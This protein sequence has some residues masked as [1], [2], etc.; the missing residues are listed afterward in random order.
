MMLRKKVGVQTCQSNIV[1]NS[2]NGIHIM[3]L[4]KPATILAGATTFISP[5]VALQC[6]ET[7]ALIKVSY[8]IDRDGWDGLHTDRDEYDPDPRLDLRPSGNIGKSTDVLKVTYGS[9]EDVVDFEAC[10]PR[11]GACLELTVSVFPTDSYAI[12]WDGQ[13]VEVGQEFDWIGD[14]ITSTEVGNFC[15]PVCDGDTE[16]LFE[17]DYWTGGV[18][19][20]AYR[21]EDQDDNAIMECKSDY[22]Y[23]PDCA[24]SLFSIYRRRACLPKEGCY[25]FIIGS[26]F[27]WVPH[28]TDYYPK[29]SIH[30]DGELVK[31]SN[32]FWRFESA[33]FGS[34][35]CLPDCNPD[36]ESMVEF[37]MYRYTLLEF[38]YV[39]TSS[40]RTDLDYN[41]DLSVS[42]GSSPA[43]LA[44]SGVVPLCSNTTLYHEK[45]CIPKESCASFYLSSLNDTNTGSSAYALAMDGVSYRNSRDYE[46]NQ[47]T[48]MGSCTAEALCDPSQEVLFEMYLQTP[49]RYTLDGM[50]SLAIFYNSINWIFGW[51][52]G[53]DYDLLMQANEYNDA[54][55]DFNSTYRTIE[56][57][58]N[59]QCEYDFNMTSSSPVES[60]VV[61]RSGVELSREVVAPYYGGPVDMTAFGE[62]NCAPAASAASAK[63]K[64]K[65][66]GGAIA[67]IVIA[68]L[69]AVGAAIYGV[70][71]YK[72][73]N[74]ATV[75]GDTFDRDT[76]TDDLLS[77]TL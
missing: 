14:K 33:A 60:Y 23:D 31:E 35:S 66:S 67:G 27:I 61:K 54:A 55:Y 53:T 30:Y 34:D 73:R 19:G 69:V 57:V 48:N 47:T 24:Q 2:I 29:F 16:A 59:A 76:L 58:P 40:P 10:I 39:C 49:T 38:D 65:L 42:H 64:E 21:V 72:K 68:S 62:K 74:R 7:D 50:S 36:S 63:K 32:D 17:Y 28:E 1:T 22:V 45:T 77:S 46:L 5:T 6:N 52:D 20:Y 25:Q 51:N 9:F 12:S 41:W 11:E 44:S 37:F 56:C 18:D 43:T 75:E 3:K 70:M 13:A 71:L 4:S 8:T 15:L 26:T